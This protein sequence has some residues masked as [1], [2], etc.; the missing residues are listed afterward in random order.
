MPPAGQAGDYSTLAH[1]Y[2]SPNFF[3]NIHHF[4]TTPP[5]HPY[6]LLHMSGTRLCSRS[7]FAP[8]T[9]LLFFQALLFFFIHVRFILFS[10]F[11]HFLPAALIYVAFY[12]YMHIK[13]QHVI[14]KTLSFLLCHGDFMFFFLIIFV[15]IIIF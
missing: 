4:N 5:V 11:V 3:N 7:K 6:L 13:I 15:F 8:A 1:Y 14:K 9:D 10:T 12:E 2:I